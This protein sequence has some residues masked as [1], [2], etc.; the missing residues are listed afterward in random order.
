MYIICPGC[1]GLRGVGHIVFTMVFNIQHFPRL[2]LQ[3]TPCTEGGTP[4]KQAYLL[5]TTDIS[6]NYH[7]IMIRSLMSG[8]FPECAISCMISLKN[9]SEW[10]REVHLVVISKH[11]LLCTANTCMC[12]V[13]GVAN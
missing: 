8:I 11:W 9:I 4:V 2:L 3:R 1:C 12:V 13:V 7:Q 5:S 10:S 6:T